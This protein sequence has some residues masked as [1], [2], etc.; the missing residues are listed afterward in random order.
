MDFLTVYAAFGLLTT[1]YTAF[2]DPAPRVKGLAFDLA[3]YTIFGLLWPIVL[4]G[5]IIIYSHQRN[6]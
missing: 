6:P 5:S 4:I 3:L 2:A 1:A